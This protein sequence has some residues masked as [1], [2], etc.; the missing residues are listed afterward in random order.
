MSQAVLKG[1]ICV[2]DAGKEYTVIEYPKH[3]MQTTV[4]NPAGKERFFRTKD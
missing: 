1:F 4:L 3:K 2:N